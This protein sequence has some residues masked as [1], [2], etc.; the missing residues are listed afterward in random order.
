MQDNGMKWN[1]RPMLVRGVSVSDTPA[2]RQ[3]CQP[4]LEG[5]HTWLEFELIRWEQVEFGVVLLR[6]QQFLLPQLPRPL[7][8]E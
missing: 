6:M 4:P 2:C 5:K 3:Q 7:P 8:P 1:A